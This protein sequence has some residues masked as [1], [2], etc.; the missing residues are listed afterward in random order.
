MM[1]SSLTVGDMV[2]LK[3]N[4]PATWW[5]DKVG[6]VVSVGEPRASILERDNYPIE[7]A[8][9]AGGEV[10]TLYSCTAYLKRCEIVSKRSK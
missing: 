8:V 1:S 6:F 5:R 7:L 2:H 4:C 3:I 9:I 10:R